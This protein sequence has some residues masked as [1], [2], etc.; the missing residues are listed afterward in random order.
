MP[1]SATGALACPGGR[2]LA[3]ARALG[4]GSRGEANA[5]LKRVRTAGLQRDRGAPAP[6]LRMPEGVSWV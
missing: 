5:M 2:D 3:L 1:E 4:A 6:S